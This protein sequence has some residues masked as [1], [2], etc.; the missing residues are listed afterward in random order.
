MKLIDVF[1]KSQI[2]KHFGLWSWSFLCIPSIS[3]M[4]LNSNSQLP[5]DPSDNV[6][7]PTVNNVFASILVKQYFIV[8]SDICGVVSISWISFSIIIIISNVSE[9]PTQHSCRCSSPNPSSWSS[10][11]W[12]APASPA[13]TSPASSALSS[14]QSSTPVNASP[15]GLSW[16]L[17]IS[18]AAW[19]IQLI[20][21]QDVE[22]GENELV[23]DDSFWIF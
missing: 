22:T 10:L 21:E 11:S 17:N 5:S 14:S 3:I 15:P 16:E 12:S 2:K 20:Q 18:S 7:Q 1:L 13:S 6:L 9:M 8:L 23:D 4:L 19:S